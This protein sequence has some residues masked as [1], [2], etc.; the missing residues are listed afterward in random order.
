LID[1]TDFVLLEGTSAIWEEFLE[2]GFPS[3]YLTCREETM[4]RRL[5]LRNRTSENNMRQGKEERK[6]LNFEL[7]VAF[8]SARSTR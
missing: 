4:L 7:T 5:K 6:V 8:L 2:R 1:A 3:I